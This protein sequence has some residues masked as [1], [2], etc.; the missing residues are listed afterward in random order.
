MGLKSPNDLRS[1]GSCRGTARS[2]FVQLAMLP[3][4]RS[5]VY[6]THSSVITKGI[7]WEKGAE[8]KGGVLSVDLNSMVSQGKP[9][10]QAHRWGERGKY[11]S[12]VWWF[13]GPNDIGS[14]NG[15]CVIVMASEK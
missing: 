8:D 12:M 5:S 4:C 3:V 10:E 14:P 9:G 1:Y 6:V 11:E 15:N 2:Q 13:K 7:P